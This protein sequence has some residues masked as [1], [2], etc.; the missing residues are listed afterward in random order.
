MPYGR[1]SDGIVTSFLHGICDVDQAELMS[2]RP[3]WIVATVAIGYDPADHSGANFY[4]WTSR[5]FGVI[6]R[7]N[8][9]YGS[10]GTIPTVEHYEQF[11]ARCANF[12]GAS[13]G[14]YRVIIG[15]EPNHE[16]ER[17]GGV[18][19]T[20]EQYARCFTMC[21]N[22]IKGVSVQI[23]VMPAAIAPYHAEG[24][25][26][27]EYW[28]KMLER[29]KANGGCD[30]IILH[31]YTR[32]SNPSDI[33]STAMMGPPLEGQ[34]SGFLTYQNQAD[35]ATAGGFGGLPAY[36]TEFNELLEHGWDDANTGVVQA[37]YHEINEW[38]LAGEKPQ[39]HALCL[40]RSNRDDK[41][42]F[43]DKNG[44]KDDFRQAVTTG[45][46]V[47]AGEP[48]GP[49]PTPT[50]PDPAP[51]PTPPPPATTYPTFWDERLTRRGCTLTQVQATVGVDVWR[52]T[53]G[54]WFDEDE[55]GGRTNIFVRVLDAGG[56]LVIAEPVT[57]FWGS[58]SSTKPTEHKSD[59]W[60]ASMGLGADY[61]LDFGMDNVAPS[62]GLRM[63]SWELS[64]II[65]GC[66]LGSLEQPDYKIHTA[67]FFEIQLVTASESVV[68]PRP[69]PTPQVKLIW[70]VVGA[71]ISQRFGENYDYY[72]QEYAQPG[73]NGLDMAAPPGTPVV[74]A[75]DGIIAW[76]GNDETGYGNYIRVSHPALALDTFY[77][78]LGTME[79]MQGQHVAQGQL[80]GTVGMTGNS[81]GPHLHY[82]LRCHDASGYHNVSFGYSNGRA[83]PEVIYWLLGEPKTYP[84]GPGI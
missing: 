84:V 69:T 82:E 78:H 9:G 56:Q 80:I 73:H 41:W 28:R 65:N 15:N 58:G 5:G 60:L 23:Q 39:I 6:V 2:D 81:T 33:T 47:A 30:G 46:T 48:S 66:G 19:I 67:Y 51:E 61:S 37:A 4:A 64:D 8:N 44:V 7:L 63:D 22:A 10:T 29:I 79:V 11:A 49:V 36:V 20:P 32:S 74:A 3:G 83:N 27:M 71:V 54:R 59:P 52:V 55:A 40:Y 68:P 13:P 12:V 75:G 70:P 43:A 42:S 25:D 77:A 24:M 38:N 18:Y 21:R 53:V 1:A 50:P 26:C 35:I 72:L 16:N 57:F 34:Y 14:V 17:P 45:Y 31:A 62:Y 76:T